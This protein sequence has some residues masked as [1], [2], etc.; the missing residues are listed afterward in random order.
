MW[1]RVALLINNLAS[2]YDVS[3]SEVSF[4]WK[5]SRN[6]GTQSHSCSGHGLCMMDYSQINNLNR[7]AVSGEASY[8]LDSIKLSLGEEKGLGFPE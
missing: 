3:N 8:L 7:T 2:L 6:V 4:L 5:F 1:L